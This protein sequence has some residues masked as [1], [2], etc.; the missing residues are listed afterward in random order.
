METRHIELER[1]A[2]KATGYKSAL[3]RA[4]EARSLELHVAAA[5]LLGHFKKQGRSPA[6]VR[7]VDLMAG[8]GYLGHFLESLGFRQVWALEASPEMSSGRPVVS[9]L[10]RIPFHNWSELRPRLEEIQPDAIVSLAGFHHLIQHEGKSINRSASIAWQFEIAHLCATMLSP[11]GILAIVDL[12]EP[13]TAEGATTKS[14]ASWNA[15]SFRRAD[16][17]PEELRERLAASTTLGGYNEEIASIS[18]KLEGNP[19]LRWFRDI[20]HTQTVLGHDDIAI[21]SELIRLLRACHHVE[22]TAFDCPW[23]FLTRSDAA[24]YTFDKFGFALSGEWSEARAD[25]LLQGLRTTTG[26]CEEKDRVFMGWNLGALVI[27][28]SQPPPDQH[29]SDANIA[30]GLA[31]ALLIIRAAL[32]LFAYNPEAAEMLAGLTWMAGGAG[33]SELIKAIRASWVRRTKG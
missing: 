26:L 24:R 9:S 23:V 4:P 16:I 27:E 31:T 20:V 18:S 11:S 12:I 13:G 5:I 21:S 28:G 15:E 22:L 30:F 6:D 17:L 10:R 33:G 3:S 8:S 32:K 19:S 25:Q 7:I 2:K 1:F 14:V 29:L